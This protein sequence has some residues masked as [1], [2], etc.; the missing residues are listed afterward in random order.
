M[1]GFST[2]VNLDGGV[3]YRCSPRM[4]GSLQMYI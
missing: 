2:D 1:M 3:S 4:V